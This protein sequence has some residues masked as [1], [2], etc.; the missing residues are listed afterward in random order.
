MSSA[1]QILRDEHDK[2][3]EMLDCLEALVQRLA[4]GESFPVE[5]LSD[6]TDFFVLFADRSHHGKEED[7]LFPLLERKGV[8]R[9]GGPLGCM[10]GEHEE[11]RAFVG[12]M[13]QNTKESAR[14][15][16]AA[17]RAWTGA[18]RGYAQLLRKHISK[19]NEILFQIAE[20]IL[21]NEEQAELELQFAQAQAQ[22]LD[23]ATLSKLEQTR[24]KI[25]QE[26]AAAAE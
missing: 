14:G 7:L 3:L 25:A 21:S 2:I 5:T 24:K 8:P 23:Q 22:K 26:L 19:E 12:M 15:N 16:E 20:H 4:A 11:G 10:L 17:R 6:L 18:A 1:I 9:Q 13:K